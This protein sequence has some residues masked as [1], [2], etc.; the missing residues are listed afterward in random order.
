MLRVK[1][2]IQ[3]SRMPVKNAPGMVRPTSSAER[4]PMLAT[5]RISTRTMAVITLLS[6]SPSR[7]ST[8]CD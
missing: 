2:S 4:R 6:R 1:P 8:S 3:I 5:T 7:L